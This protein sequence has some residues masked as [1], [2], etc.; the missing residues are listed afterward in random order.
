MNICIFEMSVKRSL[1]T[2]NL[3]GW[4]FHHC[5]MQTVWPGLWRESEMQ[6]WWCHCSAP[7]D[8][9]ERA[10]RTVHSMLCHAGRVYQI[11][12]EIK[13]MSDLRQ[14]RGVCRSEFAERAR[15]SAASQWSWSSSHLQHWK[16]TTHSHGVSEIRTREWVKI[17]NGK[18]DPDV[19]LLDSGEIKSHLTVSEGFLIHVSSIPS[20]ECGHVVA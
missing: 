7:W 11:S 13:L 6:H 12:V 10:E 8:E 3:I 5:R 14:I 17:L 19:P 4:W 18:Q 15:P 20:D 1:R 9:P 16:N 2:T